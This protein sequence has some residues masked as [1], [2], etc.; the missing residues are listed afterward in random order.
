M[1]RDGNRIKGYAF[2]EF[3][4]KLQLIE[5]LGNNDL[6]SICLICLI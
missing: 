2:V 5:A 6:V 4:D 3:E 1:P